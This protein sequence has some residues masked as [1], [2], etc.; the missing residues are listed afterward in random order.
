MCLSAQGYDDNSN[1]YWSSEWIW[2][3]ED[4]KG[5]G[6]II[7]D[8]VLFAHDCMNDCRYEEAV[9]I[10]K[11]VMDAQI[12]VEDEC[13]GDSFELS[14]EEM[15]NEKL[16]G[17]NLKVLA[18]DVLYSNYQLQTAAQCA[19]LLYSYFTYPYFKEIH[20]ED[21][22]SIGR[23]ELRDTDMFFQS[24]IDFLMRESGEVAARLL[25]EGILYYKGTLGLVEMARKCYKEHPSVYLAV[26][27]EYEKVHDYEKMKEIGKEALENLECD[28]KI[29]GEIAIKTAQASCCVNDSEFMKKCWY[30][31]FYSNSTIPNYLR[32]F[33]NKEVIGEYKGLAEKRIEK[34]RISE[35]YYDHK[36]ETAK[37]D[38][39]EIQYKYL[40]FFSG[41]FDKIKN[42]CMEQKRSLGWSGNFIGY[43]VDFML[44]YLYM[45]HN[46]R[47]A[48][49]S[50]ATRVSNRIGLTECKNLVFIKE[51]FVFETDVSKQK[52]EEIFWDV[53][54][55][56]KA[57]YTISINDVNI[58]VD[59]IESVINK[60]ANAIVDG[61]YRNKYN[62]VALLIAALGEVK[63]SIGVKMCKSNIIKN[64]WT[65]IRDIHPFERH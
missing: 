56:W 27:L 20:I 53:F 7:E 3:Y 65:C 11:L 51:N 58:H 23:E 18:L 4:K 59:W 44:L 49:K 35:N 6:R 32:L 60:R 55:L 54:C 2:E 29:R 12:Y 48:G 41:H 15:V 50:I 1:G 63:E 46:P 9:T 42:W 17:V 64:I 24:W 52:S 47:K 57:N 31:A 16:V 45:D 61:K 33:V 39:D 13:G 37:N 43:G 38:I 28:L 5:I 22:F 8:A 19:S 21:I 62:D 34:L 14:L 10:Y 25:K 26:L 30:E 40:H 36:S